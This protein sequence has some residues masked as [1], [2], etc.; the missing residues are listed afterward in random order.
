VHLELVGSEAEE[1]TR[2]LDGGFPILGDELVRLLLGVVHESL[3]CGSAG[4]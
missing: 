2:L 1:R 4:R 3:L